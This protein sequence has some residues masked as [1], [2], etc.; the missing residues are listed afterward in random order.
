M[1]SRRGARALVVLVCAAQLVP[2]LPARADERTITCE[3][4][5]YQY[6][7]CRADTDNRVSLVRQRSSTRCQLWDNWGYDGRGVWVDR[8]CAG[9]FRVGKGGSGGT[10]AAVGAVA[11]AAIIAAIIAG[12]NNDNHQDAVPSW[13]VGTYRGYDDVEG[14]DVEITIYPSGSATGVAGTHEFTG[15]WDGDRLQAGNYRFRVERSGNGFRATDERDSNHR[16]VFRRSS[17]G[18]Y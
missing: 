9:E 1:K 11:G 7:Y 14:A 17:G 3:S 8:G 16:I 10:A 4:R 13:A 15:R 18:G 12:K 5:S 2:A 6:N